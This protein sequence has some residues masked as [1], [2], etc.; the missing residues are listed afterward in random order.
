MVSYV[1][2]LP[3]ISLRQR[4][5]RPGSEVF[6]RGSWQL[7]RAPQRAI[8]GKSRSRRVTFVRQSDPPLPAAS[9]SGI[10]RALLAFRSA[11]RAPMPPACDDGS[12][13]TLPPLTNQVDSGKWTRVHPRGPPRRSG[14]DF[15]DLLMEDVFAP[16]E[17]LRLQM[18]TRRRRG[19]GR[20]SLLPPPSLRSC[21]EPTWGRVR[22]PHQQKR[23]ADLGGGLCCPFG[24]SHAWA[25]E[26]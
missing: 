13:P 20:V 11:G 26:A 6:S 16:C 19:G 10:P 2:S 5:N 22:L 14:L 24:M 3:G 7:H 12:N 8:S 25:R 21:G 18:H 23:A 4:R 9:R 17:K 15:L 1:G